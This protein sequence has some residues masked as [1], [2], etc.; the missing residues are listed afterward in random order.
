MCNKCNDKGW[1]AIAYSA[2]QGWIWTMCKSCEGWRNNPKP[3]Q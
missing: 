2:F 3:K 1:V